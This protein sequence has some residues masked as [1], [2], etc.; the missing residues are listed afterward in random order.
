[1]LSSPCGRHQADRRLDRLALAVAAAE[2]PLEHA[3]VLAEAG[4]EELAVV[5]LAEPVDEE[6]PRQLRRVAS[7]AD[8]QPVA[9]VVGHVV[10][11]EGQHR[12]RV[13]AQLADLAGRRGGRLRGHR[14][15]EEDA[16]LPVEGLGDQRHHGRAAAAEQ[17]GVDRHA[18]RVLPLRRRSTGTARPAW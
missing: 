6:D 4:P 14:R 9:E 5:V 11:A 10:A 16:V 15:A 7:R 2:D 8:L 3:A 17:E 18:G 13:E 1:M 12:H